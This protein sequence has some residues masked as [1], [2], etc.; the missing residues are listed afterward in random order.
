MNH[1][2]LDGIVAGT[3]EYGGDYFA[4]IAH[5]SA[6]GTGYFN[7]RFPGEALVELRRTEQGNAT[8]QRVLITAD[9]PHDVERGRAL[10]VAGRLQHRDYQVTLE[11]FIERANDAELTDEE[12]ETLLALAE[13]AG[14][15]NRSHYEIVVS[16][17][18]LY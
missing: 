6:E 7:V 17:V 5:H 4:R 12:R 14:R 2:T 8:Q 1:V 10:L 15:E 11:E 16:E 9:S 18:V 3:W 13:K